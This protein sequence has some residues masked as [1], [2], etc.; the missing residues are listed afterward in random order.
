MVKV[1]SIR[2]QQRFGPFATLLVEASS[3]T[4]LFR[5][6]SSQVFRSPQVE[7]YISSEGHPFF[8]KCSQLNLNLENV[9]KN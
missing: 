4:G 2:F 3:E 5:H 7:K 9:I 8:S 6:L 1:L